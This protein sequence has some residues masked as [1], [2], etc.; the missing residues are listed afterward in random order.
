MCLVYKGIQPHCFQVLQLDRNFER[1]QYGVLQP[2]AFSLATALE[3]Q[4]QPFERKKQVDEVIHAND[5]AT[6]TRLLNSLEMDFGTRF[7]RPTDPSHSPSGMV[8][9]HWRNIH[10]D[11]TTDSTF[12]CF[13][14]SNTESMVEGPLNP[15]FRQAE[16]EFLMRQHCRNVYQPLKQFMTRHLQHVRYVRPP[17]GWNEAGDNLQGNQWLDLIAGFTSGGV[18]CGVY[19]T[20]VRIPRSWITAPGAYPFDGSAIDLTRLRIAY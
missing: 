4:Q 7:F 9:A 20:D 10:V 3:Q 15:Q 18:L 17:H 2:I 12:C 16:Y 1:R 14:D 13:C 5:I 6:L 11:S 19:L 8:E